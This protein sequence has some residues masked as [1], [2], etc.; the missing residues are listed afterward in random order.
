MKAE[1]EIIEEARAID[2]ANSSDHP[3]GSDMDEPDP[4]MPELVPSPELAACE[5]HKVEVV[6][7]QQSA[8]S[9]RAQ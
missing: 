9:D 7:E 4:D 6:E 8:G 1:R 2:A 5:K 3:G